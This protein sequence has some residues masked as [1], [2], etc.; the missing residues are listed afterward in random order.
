MEQKCTPNE[1]IEII[2]KITSAL[3][4]GRIEEITLR[5]GLNEHIKYSAH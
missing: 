4:Y 2:N 1:L 5:T 3:G